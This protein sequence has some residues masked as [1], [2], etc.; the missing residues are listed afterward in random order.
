MFTRNTIVIT[1]HQKQRPTRRP[2]IKLPSR[3]Q[4]K[5]IRIIIRNRRLQPNQRLQRNR[6]PQP[7]RK[8]GSFKDEFFI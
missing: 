6:R 8:K 2:R 3:L 5:T 1:M 7:K 4:P